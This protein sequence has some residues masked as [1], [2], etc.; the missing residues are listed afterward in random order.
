[1]ARWKKEI[2]IKAK[3]NQKRHSHKEDIY[4]KVKLLDKVTLYLKDGKKFTGRVIEKSDIKI[5]ISIERDCAR[6]FL[7]TELEDIKMA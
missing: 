1:M 4:Q 7:R 2:A 6:E 5:R 3:E